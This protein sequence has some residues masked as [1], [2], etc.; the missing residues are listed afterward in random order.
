MFIEEKRLWHAL[1]RI[2]NKLDALLFAVGRVWQ[3]ERKMSTE[4]QSLQSQVTETDGVIDSAVT[5]INGLA[6]QIADLKD[7]PAALQAL[8]DDLKSKSD[9]LAA[10]VAANTSTDSGSGEPAPAT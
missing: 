2:E 10:A 3:E 6:A 7:D 1:T 4:L 9:A 8:S 5:L